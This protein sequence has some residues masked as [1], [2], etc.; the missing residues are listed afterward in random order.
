MSL[1]NNDYHN[2]GRPRPTPA[3][4]APQCPPPHEALRP[5]LSSSLHGWQPPGQVDIIWRGMRGCMALKILQ[6]CGDASSLE[7]RSALRDIYP[8][9]LSSVPSQIIFVCTG[10]C[11]PS[12]LWCIGTTP[13]ASCG[14]VR[15]PFLP[16][17]AMVRHSLC[18]FCGVPEHALFLSGGTTP[19]W[20]SPESSRLE[21]DK[22]CF[23]LMLRLR[24]NREKKRNGKQ[25][26][27]PSWG[28]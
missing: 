7:Q 11:R 16:A 25:T 8:L 5:F 13:N 17:T 24:E 27:S 2:N 6:C 19:F 12:L 26:S 3:D 14:I 18:M 4:M 22:S 15:G 10:S 23:A 9:T 1:V 20:V 21:Q 28:C